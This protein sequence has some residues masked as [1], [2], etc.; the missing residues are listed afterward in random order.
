M[1][2]TA[3][4]T[5]TGALKILG[6]LDPLETMKPEQADQGM[7]V[8]ADLVDLLAVD[9]LV[10]YATQNLT[11]TFAG[12][13]ATVGPAGTFATTTPRPLR[14]NHGFY[15]KSGIDYLITPLQTR[16]QYDSISQKSISTE[17]PQYLWYDPQVPLGT[18]FV[19]PVPA[20]LNDYFL[21]VDV[22]LTEFAT[23]DTV[24]NV[25][26][27]YRTMLKYE[28]ARMLAPIFQV[29]MP[30]DAEKVRVNAMNLIKRMNT[31][32]PKMKTDTIQPEG[33]TY[34]ILSN[35]FDGDT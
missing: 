23:L 31:Q 25:P 14:I 34:N 11:A 3:R 13:S 12:S 6:V 24:Y 17:Y 26:Q 19:W 8:L 30:A 5:I 22:L 28:L 29:P 2:I 1:A 9:S 7:E 10:I 27:G 21:N 35:Q 32:V 20:G 15:R 4:G 18:V 16:E 33:R